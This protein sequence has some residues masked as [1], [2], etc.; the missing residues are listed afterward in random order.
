MTQK[1]AFGHFFFFKKKGNMTL[2]QICVLFVVM[3][4][5]D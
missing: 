1:Y 4:K 5:S 2:I 3:R